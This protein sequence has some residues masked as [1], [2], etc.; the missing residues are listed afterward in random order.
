MAVLLTGGAG[1]VGLNI[2]EALLRRGQ[3]VVALDASR[4]PE[5]AKSEFV[6]LG[7]GLR[8]VPGDVR[9]RELLDRIFQNKV[10]AEGPIDA[11]VHAAA[12]TAGSQRER[13]DPALIAEI[14]LLGTVRVIE[15]AQRAGVRRIVVLST[16]SVY[17]EAGRTEDGAPLDEAVPRPVPSNLYGITK[18]AAER[19]SLRLAELWGLDLRVGR[20]AVVFGCWERETG[21]RDGMS[22]VLQ[23]T[24]AAERGEA[25]VLPRQA[26]EDWIY[27]PDLAEAVVTLLSAAAPPRRVYNLGTGQPWPLAAWCDRLRATFP[28]F[29]CRFSDDPA[30]VTASVLSTS[31]LRAPFA[32]RAVRDELGF[33]PR[34]DMDRAFDHYLAWRRA[35]PAIG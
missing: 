26:P 7:A 19:S 17:G 8:V 9:D 16:G 35:H 28:G 21:Y 13:D 34:Y 3:M 2:A 20:P 27:A 30:E 5:T 11:V 29:T 22:L 25:I 14:N 15:A 23:A 1:F 18:Y 10:D 32:A 24:R 33:R 6:G 12:L 31:S 4:I